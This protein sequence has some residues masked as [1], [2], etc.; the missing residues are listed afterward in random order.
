M[1]NVPFYNKWSS[2]VD[3]RDNSRVNAA[4]FNYELKG[5][6][7][8]PAEPIENI[9]DFFK[10]GLK[11]NPKLQCFGWKNGDHYDFIV[12]FS[13]L[14]L[15]KFNGSVLRWWSSPNPLNVLVMD[16]LKYYCLA[17]KITH[18]HLDCVMINGKNL[19]VLH[20]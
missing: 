2:V 15:W 4:C 19:R 20:N 17:A 5:D 13:S 6:F 18:T 14:I 8:N 3:P 9:Y 11:T 16:N 1:R 12:E 10:I 7:D